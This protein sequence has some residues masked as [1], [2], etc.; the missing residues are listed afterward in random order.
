VSA[1]E[2][3]VLGLTDEELLALPRPP[4]P[5]CGQAGRLIPRVNGMPSPDDPLLRRTEMGEI[6]VEFAGC[7]IPVDPLPVWRCV[8]CDALVAEDGSLIAEEGYE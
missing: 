5:R 1:V 8:V 6:E 2:D 3:D 4:C 7:V